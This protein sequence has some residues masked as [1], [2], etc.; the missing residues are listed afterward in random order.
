[1]P[2]KDDY[3]PTLLEALND[4]REAWRPF[5]QWYMEQIKRLLIL[6]TKF[7]RWIGDANVRED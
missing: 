1:M 7:L 5:E 6:I 3:T 2:N 4:L